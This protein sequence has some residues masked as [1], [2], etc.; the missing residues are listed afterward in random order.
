MK[1]HWSQKFLVVYSGVLTF[2]F[3]LVV[4]VGIARPFALREVAAAPAN[5][6]T[7]DVIDVHRINVVEPDG[8]LRLVIS[9]KAKFPGSF[10][11]GKEIARPD[12]HD[13]GLLFMNDEGTEMGGL[14]FDGAKQKDGQVENNGH[15]SFDQYEQ[16]QMFSIDAGQGGSRKQ[17]MMIFS[18]RGDYSL[19]DSI[20]DLL[21]MKTLPSAERQA[22]MEKFV[23][24]HPGDHPRILF[25]R[26]PDKSVVL[27]MKDP[28]GRDRLVMKV[29]PDGVPALQFLD[30]SG[31][32]I[33]QFPKSG[34]GG[35]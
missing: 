11:R 24:T 20:D 23:A 14:T 29:S 26:A 15:L 21:R 25:G 7:F 31:K 19:Y 13:T 16:D 9:D 1:M 17:T 2:A 18:D 12:R 10:L 8:T 33:E 32:V 4:F 3:A 28:E 22:A 35:N 34:T 30:N 5:K 6:V 27:R